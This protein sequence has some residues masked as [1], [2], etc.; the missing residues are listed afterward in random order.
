MFHVK[1]FH[2]TKRKTF[3]KCFYCSQ[4]S[5][6]F[7]KETKLFPYFFSVI[8]CEKTAIPAPLPEWDKIPGKRDTGL[9]NRLQK[10]LQGVESRQKKLHLGQ[11][12]A[13]GSMIRG[14]FFVITG[15]KGLSQ[16]LFLLFH[17]E[18]LFQNGLKFCFFLHCPPSH[19]TIFLVVPALIGLYKG[20][21]FSLALNKCT[22]S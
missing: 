19:H 4:R 12:K 22:L 21:S 9:Q 3:P 7:K 17:K 11:K 2:A 1:Q 10:A 18:S 13:H 16:R 15:S 14:L 8:F 6:Y 5:I 20:W